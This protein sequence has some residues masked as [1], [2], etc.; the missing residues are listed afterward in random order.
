MKNNMPRNACVSLMFAAVLVWSSF[1]EALRFPHETAGELDSTY[2]QLARLSEVILIG[3]ITGIST[4]SPD[5]LNYAVTVEK[6]L[7]G[8][9]GPKEI[10]LYGFTRKMPVIIPPQRALIFIPSKD[11]E[12]DLLKT[13]S[14]G[15]QMAASPAKETNE[16]TVRYAKRAIIPLDGDGLSNLVSVVE[17]YLYFLRE[18]TPDKIEPYFWF[19]HGLLSDGDYRVRNDATTDMIFLCHSLD[20]D[21]LSI[22]CSPQNDLDPRVR[23]Y[24]EQRIKWVREGRPVVARDSTPTEEQI[25]GWLEDLKSGD[26]SRNGM[27]LLE[28]SSRTNWLGQSTSVW[29]DAVADL[30]T[31]S[32]QPTRLMSADMLSQIND[33]RAVPVLIE[34]LESSTEGLRR[35]CWDHLTHFY[36]TPVTY[37]PVAPEAERK[38]MAA[39]WME[40]YQQQMP[41]VGSQ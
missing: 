2:G 33:R 23:E 7:S 35:G 36:G 19:L 32:N 12:S 22:L 41:R 15:W 27:A 30:L 20:A 1:A 10:F 17:K 26:R 29:A 37:D 5:Q 31:Y 34:G 6:V 18:P 39:K 40:W 21:T 24:A 8:V 38:A 9:V 28:M 25:Q 14:W 3:N 13:S 4:N 11:I 16:W